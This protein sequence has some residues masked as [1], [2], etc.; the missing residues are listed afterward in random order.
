M[1]VVST[2]PFDDWAQERIRLEGDTILSILERIRAEQWQLINSEAI[3]VEL[4]KMRNLE[5]KEQI[6]KLLELA[7]MLQSIDETID[8]RA[9]QLENMG[10]GLFDAFH[11]ACAEAR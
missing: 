8:L 1:S 4:E 7:T 9:Q 3:A 6:L 5:K 2:R 11:L 10:F